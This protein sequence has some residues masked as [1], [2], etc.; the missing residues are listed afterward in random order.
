MEDVNFCYYSSLPSTIV[1]ME[2]IDKRLL[3]LSVKDIQRVEGTRIQIKKC[4]QMVCSKFKL[5][6]I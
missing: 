1:Y 4:Y 6:K 2:V 3:A 5:N